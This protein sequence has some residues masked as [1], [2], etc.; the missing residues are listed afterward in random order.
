[1]SLPV[2]N[3]APILFCATCD[4]QFSALDVA[5][6]R[7][8]VNT[9]RCYRCQRADYQAPASRS[10][11]GTSSYDDEAPECSRMCP[12]RASC[13]DW[14]GGRMLKRIEFTKEM[15]EAAIALF[16][17]RS[18]EERRKRRRE[19]KHP[20]PMR[21]S[22]IRVIW[23]LAEKGTTVGKIQKLCDDIGAK[24]AYYLRQLRREFANGRKWKYVEEEGDRFRV[25]LLD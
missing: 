24:P 7:W 1:M 25:T 6:F 16:R 11:F 12:D 21:G 14:Q 10:C 13:P 3:P 5:L 19:A 8:D 20:F 22:I 23:D 2:L 17:A 18:S 4:A 9:A 15:R